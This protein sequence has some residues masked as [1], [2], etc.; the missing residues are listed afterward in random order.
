MQS[1]RIFEFEV[2]RTGTVTDI[3]RAPSLYDEHSSQISYANNIIR[4]PQEHPS[5]ASD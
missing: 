5:H 1:S 4:G 3:V 2:R